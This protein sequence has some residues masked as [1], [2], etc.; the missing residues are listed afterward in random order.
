M[1]AYPKP[2]VVITVTLTLGCLPIDMLSWLISNVGKIYD[3]NTLPMNV[4]AYGWDAW[5]SVYSGENVSVTFR[6]DD[7]RKATLFKLT[8]G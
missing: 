6:F 2:D 4:C 3:S 5:A 8:W 7:P 1:N